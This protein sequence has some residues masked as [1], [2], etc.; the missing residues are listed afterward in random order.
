[1]RNMSLP[2]M[3]G[4]RIIDLGVSYLREAREWWIR[5][6]HT[7]IVVPMSNRFATTLLQ[8]VDPS[9]GQTFEVLWTDGSV[10]TRATRNNAPEVAELR[11]GGMVATESPKSQWYFDLYASPK[12]EVLTINIGGADYRMT[13]Q[14]VPSDNPLAE[15]E[16]FLIITTKGTG[17]HAFTPLL[18]MVNDAINEDSGVAVNVWNWQ[19]SFWGHT[20]TLPRRSLDTIILPNRVERDVVKDLLEFNDSEPEYVRLGTPYR[21][22]YFFYGTPRSGKSALIGVMASMS[23]R[24]LFVLNV[25]GLHASDDGLIQAFTSLPKDAI[26]VIEDVDAMSGVS[27]SRGDND[28]NRVALSTLLNCLDGTFSKNNVVVVMTTNHKE[29]LDP[30]LIGSGRMD[31]TLE[32]GLATMGQVE[33]L[34]ELYFPTERMPNLPLPQQLGVPMAEVQSIFQRNRRAPHKAWEALYAI[35]KRD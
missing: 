32:F 21:R 8:M 18:R 17:K 20:T 22:G 9:V 5:R 2:I 31:Y 14:N 19:N 33:G 27:V 13:V 16:D 35:A 24:N 29:N 25:S 11:R 15:G 30:A 34:W 10:V 4:D 6:T 3:A 26:L 1:M 23:G 12:H 7:T 28:Q